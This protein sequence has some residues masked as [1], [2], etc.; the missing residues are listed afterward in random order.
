MNTKSLIGALI[1]ACTFPYAATASA[2]ESTPKDTA[3]GGGSYP[4]RLAAVDKALEINIGA[5]Y[6]QGAGN[7]GSGLPSLT[8]NGSA[9][10]AVQLGVGYRLIPQLTLGFYGTGSLFS[11]G[12]TV[13]SSAKLYSATAGFEATYHILPNRELDPWV[14]LGSGWRGY[15]SK[16][17]Q[18]TT[19]MNGIE[20]ARLQI[21]TDFRLADAVAVSPVIG[22]DLSTFLT[23][24]LPNQTSWHNVPSPS[25]NTFVFAGVQGRFDIAT[26][27]RPDS[28]VASR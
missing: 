2:D 15:W 22:A 21:G 1:V 24:E 26:G 25:V 7:V 12:D 13:D 20:L 16:T 28:S 10:G 6:A 27:S 17:D 18:G 23:Q 3:Q 11:R 9:G 19:S 5:G 8:D 4:R 14:S